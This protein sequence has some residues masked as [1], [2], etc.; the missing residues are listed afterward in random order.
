MTAESVKSLLAARMQ[1]QGIATPAG[2][3]GRGEELF[4]S[5]SC[6]RI[7]N[8]PQMMLTLEKAD[9]ETLTL[10]YSH[11]YSIRSTNPNAG[12]VLKFSEDQVEVQGRSLGRVWELIGTQRLRVLREPVGGEQFDVGAKGIVV[13]RIEFRCEDA[14]PSKPV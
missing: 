7:G 12:F 4:E 13:T 14:S 6:G 2:E 5:F 8:K 1:P 9:G 3:E 10:A 11:L